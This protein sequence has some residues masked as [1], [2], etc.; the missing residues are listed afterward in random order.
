MYIPII[1]F[2]VSKVLINCFR[3]IIEIERKE[4]IFAYSSLVIL[5]GDL[6]C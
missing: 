2:I 4:Y 1:Y 3:Y 6:L 5:L